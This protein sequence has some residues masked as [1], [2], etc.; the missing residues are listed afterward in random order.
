MAECIMCVSMP[1]CNGGGVGRQ[2]LVPVSLRPRLLRTAVV[3]YPLP[4][5]STI[6]QVSTGQLVA[7]A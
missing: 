3:P 5:D 1:A 4:P 6:P 2:V 7:S